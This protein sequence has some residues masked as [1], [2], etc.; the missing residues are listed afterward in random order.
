MITAQELRFVVDILSELRAIV[1][2]SECLEGEITEAI[3]LLRA[4]KMEPTENY[5]NFM[6]D[7]KDLLYNE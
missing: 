1:D 3:D 7:N 2:P 6:K 4:L 5:L